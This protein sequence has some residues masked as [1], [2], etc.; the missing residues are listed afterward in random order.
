MITRPRSLTQ[1]ENP[2]QVLSCCMNKSNIDTCSQQ[3]NRRKLNF[4]DIAHICKESEK[5]RAF[6]RTDSH[7]RRKEDI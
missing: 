7:H 3:A 2:R 4:D 1:Y 6:A 5:M